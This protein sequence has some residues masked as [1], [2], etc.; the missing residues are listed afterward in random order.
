ME[1]YYEKKWLI[2]DTVVEFAT[3]DGIPA[4]KVANNFSHSCKH[5]P[6]PIQALRG[7][8]TSAFILLESAT[9]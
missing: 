1:E 9:T 2:K 3:S 6:V 4:K 7:L 5:M 8:A